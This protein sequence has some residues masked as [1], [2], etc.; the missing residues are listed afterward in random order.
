MAGQSTEHAAFSS[1]VMRTVQGLIKRRSS[2]SGVCQHVIKC[3]RVP[4]GHGRQGE[5]GRP[6]IRVPRR[7][8]DPLQRLVAGFAAHR[9]FNSCMH[10]Q[11]DPLRVAAR[12]DRRPKDERS[13]FTCFC[14]E[15]SYRFRWALESHR[16]TYYPST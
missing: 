8:R 1:A 14:S 13:L 16:E 12:G 7:S 4:T 10:T 2:A 15:S 11:E 5:G 6:R 9:T 3:L